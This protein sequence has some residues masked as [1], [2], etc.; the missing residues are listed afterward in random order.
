ME[1]PK[2]NKE[3]YESSNVCICTATALDFLKALTAFKQS[4][5]DKYHIEIDNSNI[6]ICL[7]Y[8]DMICL[9]TKFSIENVNYEKE[10]VEWEQWNQKYKDVEKHNLNKR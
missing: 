10:Y 4:I 9:S 8:E 5:F 6:D 1:E 3:I 2:R 7:Y